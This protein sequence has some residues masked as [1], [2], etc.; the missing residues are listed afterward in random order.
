MLKSDKYL[1][2]NNNIFELD[3]KFMGMKEMIVNLRGFL[4]FDKFML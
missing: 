3:I 1:I 2:F 4:F